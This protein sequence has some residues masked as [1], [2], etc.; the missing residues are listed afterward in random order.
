MD[1]NSISSE[2]TSIYGLEIVTHIIRE[3]SYDVYV[4][5]IICFETILDFIQ[6]Y[7]H[8]PFDKILSKVR[9]I[10]GIILTK[11]ADT[12]KRIGEKSLQVLLVWC[13][14]V[15]D[16]MNS[17]SKRMTR[18]MVETGFDITC[19]SLT[20]DNEAID[21]ILYLIN[22]DQKEHSSSSQFPQNAMYTVGRLTCLNALLRRLSDHFKRSQQAPDYPRMMVAID[23]AFRHLQ[24]TDK[25]IRESALQIFM[26]SSDMAIAS[27]PNRTR[28]F[29][30]QLIT[31]ITDSKLR[32]Q[33]WERNASFF[34]ED[35][36]LS[37]SE[38]IEQKK[39]ASFN[40]SIIENN[41]PSDYHHINIHNK[42][43]TPFST[44]GIEE[45]EASQNHTS[46]MTFKNVSTSFSS[47]SKLEDI[48]NKFKPLINHDNEFGA[49]FY[50]EPQKLIRN[51]TERFGQNK[52]NSKGKWK[53]GRCGRDTKSSVYY[54]QILGKRHFSG[55]FGEEERGEW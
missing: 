28:Q 31:C 53:R 2:F 37:A 16:A 13:S 24:V 18:H 34:L 45:K 17:L 23:F 51:R 4:A 25:T 20:Y 46:A 22:E 40:C 48:S 38:I 49:A 42:E 41:E 12:N 1:G 30:E 50:A 44:M 32:H 35:L 15:H 33:L 43:N 55:A 47:R 29:V 5:S 10:F 9:S 54:S 36:Q 11:C 14:N 52:I 3:S 21:L 6:H 39:D 26:I 27:D 7:T 8:Q 19:P